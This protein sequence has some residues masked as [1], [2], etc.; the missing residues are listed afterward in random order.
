M[1]VDSAADS[2]K[3]KD[4]LSLTFDLYGDAGGALATAWGIFDSSN[5]YNLAATFVVDKGG[6]IIY[7]Y[8]GVGK[9]DRPS[10]AELLELAP[11][12]K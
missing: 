7:R 4:K 10:A 9:A 12:H 1:S 8:L 3:L 11:N 5:G 2:T 6:E